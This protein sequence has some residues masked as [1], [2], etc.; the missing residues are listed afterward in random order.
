MR[1]GCEY[2]TVAEFEGD[3]RA[4]DDTGGFDANYSDPTAAIEDDS[5]HGIECAAVS[6]E[7]IRCNV[8]C[9]KHRS[10]SAFGNGAQR[11]VEESYL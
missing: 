11:G 9:G 7:R 6:D 3:T 10:T 8:D 4:E 5:R 1:G 2:T